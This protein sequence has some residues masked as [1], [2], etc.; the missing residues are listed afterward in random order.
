M[1]RRRTRRLR[2]GKR[3]GEGATGKVYVPVLACNDGSEAPFRGPGFVGKAIAETSLAREL[4]HQA[5]LA[6]LGDSVIA[7]IHHCL[8]AEAQTNA[9]FIENSD[10][11]MY[12]NETS[13]HLGKKKYLTYQV[14][15]RNGGRNVADLLADR[16]NH[17]V[18][19]QAIKDF[20]PVLREFNQRFIHFD[21]HLENL[22]FD[23]TRIRIIDFENM[24]PATPDTAHVDICRIL[25]K[26]YHLLKR[27]SDA[28]P[29]DPTYNEWIA[30]NGNHSD[31]GRCVDSSYGDIIAAINSIPTV[32]APEVVIEIGLPEEN[33]VPKSK[34]G[35]N[36]GCTIMGGRF[37]AKSR[38][39]AAKS[40]RISRR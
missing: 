35:R 8:L 15:Y 7:P 12:E 2:G 11:A 38:R 28:N 22:V 3:I 5:A 36:G 24:R 25:F 37:A 23:G 13:P 16:S 9:N 6:S 30:A 40:R 10:K 39:S 27:Y 33:E 31:W 21:L 19:F 4:R 34:C 32:D 29:H 17:R 14:I 18:I 1:T 20:I 26:I